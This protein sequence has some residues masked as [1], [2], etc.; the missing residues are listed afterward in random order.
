MDM[1]RGRAFMHRIGLTRKMRRSPHHTPSL[2]R[3]S[4]PH[5]EVIE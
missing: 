2:V 4:L 5:G 1:A 3:D